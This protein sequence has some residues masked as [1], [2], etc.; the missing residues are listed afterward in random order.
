[1]M[2][3]ASHLHHLASEKGG[4]KGAMMLL[5]G[6]GGLLLVKGVGGLVLTQGGLMLGEGNRGGNLNVGPGADP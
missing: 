4:G 2:R 5:E 1:M 6:E 3:P